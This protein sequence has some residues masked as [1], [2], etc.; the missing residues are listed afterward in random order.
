MQSVFCTEINLTFG[1]IF[2]GLFSQP[3]SQLEEWKERVED[4]NGGCGDGQNL[5]PACSAPGEM[6]D[7][8][9]GQIQPA[10]QECSP[11]PPVPVTPPESSLTAG[12]PDNCLL[13][14]KGAP[15]AEVTYVHA[16][17]RP[18]HGNGDFLAL[19]Q[20][21]SLS[22]SITHSSCQLI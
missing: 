18:P 11:G 5:Q 20:G 2:Q 22:L 15:D 16:T 4:G 8:I 21:P 14:P 12:S 13:I 19:G 10:I 17:S 6:M 9:A 1:S 3:Q 7:F